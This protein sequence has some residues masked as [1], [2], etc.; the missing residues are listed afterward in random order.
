MKR[1]MRTG[2]WLALAALGSIP[3]GAQVRARTLET[4][5]NR[6]TRDAPSA[7]IGGTYTQ[8][9]TRPLESA[10]GPN[11]ALLGRRD[12]PFRGDYRSSNYS[13]TMPM[14]RLGMRGDSF[15]IA[16]RMNFF[17]AAL[18]GRDADL[19]TISGLSSARSLSLPLPGVPIGYI[20]AL[21]AYEYTPRPATTRFHD[22]LGLTP[23]E[24]PKAGATALGAAERLESRTEVV[25]HHAEEDGVELFRRGTLEP[26]DPARGRREKCPECAGQLA[27]AAN[28]LALVKDLDT[29][30]ALPLML[31][32]HVALEQERIRQAIDH[33]LAAAKRDPEVFQRETEPFDHY[34]GDVADGRSVYLAMQMRRYVRSGEYNPTSGAAYALQAYC[35][36]RLGEL[37]PAREALARVEQL[38]LTTPA[39]TEDLLGFAAALHAAIP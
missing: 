9:E 39:Q 16:G 10:R 26:L 8:T 19:A 27:Q 32:L 11:S 23:T 30:A 31:M 37:G 14:S 20:P 5:I 35:A 3:A 6:P 13:R 2:A 7:Y 29:H 34:F 38:A 28:R 17:G 15:P 18:A 4:L 12:M 22:V 36:W 21:N 25:L 33:L 1:Y 24:V